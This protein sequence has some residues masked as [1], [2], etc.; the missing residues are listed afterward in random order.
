MEAD[1]HR[2]PNRFL[3]PSAGSMCSYNATKLDGAR[4]KNGA[5]RLG[6][7]YRRAGLHTNAFCLEADATGIGWL[8]INSSRASDVDPIGM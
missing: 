1:S 8:A 3:R 6:M 7:V 5:S 4:H 2:V